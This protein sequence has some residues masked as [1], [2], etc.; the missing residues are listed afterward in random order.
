M[1]FNEVDRG[2]FTGVGIYVAISLDVVKK[3]VEASKGANGKGGKNEEMPM[4]N[5][6]A[7]WKQT[8]VK[9]DGSLPIIPNV[10]LMKDIFGD[11]QIVKKKT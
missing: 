6:E 9:K 7:E 5:I 2:E 1:D 10:S 3:K 4:G 8:I 11:K